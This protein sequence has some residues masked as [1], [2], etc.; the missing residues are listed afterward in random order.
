MRLPAQV[1]RLPGAPPCLALG[2]PPGCGE[3]VRALLD[4]CAA[5]TVVGAGLANALA[6]RYGR[7]G[8]AMRGVGGDT[9]SVDCGELSLV[10]CRD[11]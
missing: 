5:F 2:L 6:I 3:P 9:P 8:R 10:F 11:N 7:P 4:T 1:V